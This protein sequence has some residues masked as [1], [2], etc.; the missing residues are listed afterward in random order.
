MRFKRS[1][2]ANST[3]RAAALMVPWSFGNPSTRFDT[4]RQAQG[5][6]SGFR[7][8][9]GSLSLSKRTHTQ[10]SG[11]AAELGVRRLMPTI[12]YL[13]NWALLNKQILSIS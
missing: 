9:D 4:L 5:S 6:G 11:S 13:N 1:T 10:G 2:S 3:V 7:L 12:R 8:N